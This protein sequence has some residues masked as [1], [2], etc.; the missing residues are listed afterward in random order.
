MEDQTLLMEESRERERGG[1]EKDVF[2]ESCF[3]GKAHLKQ[4]REIRTT[5]FI[6][7]DSND[8]TLNVCITYHWGAFAN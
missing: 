6:D 1:G 5:F 8:K 4:A 2:T 7:H 3:S